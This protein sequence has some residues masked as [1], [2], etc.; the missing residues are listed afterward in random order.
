MA[1]CSS[2]SER[3]QESLSGLLAALSNY[4]QKVTFTATV[5]GWRVTAS[6]AYA[7]DVNPAYAADAVLRKLESRHEP[8]L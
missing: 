6:G 3:T 2:M 4:S 5:D 8:K 1:K 7:V